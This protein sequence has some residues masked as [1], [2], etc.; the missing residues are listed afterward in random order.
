MVGLIYTGFN[1]GVD[2][3]LSLVVPVHPAIKNKNKTQKK[4]ITEVS[5]NCSKKETTIFDFHLNDLL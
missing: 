2:C 5:F 4:R 3:L 1:G